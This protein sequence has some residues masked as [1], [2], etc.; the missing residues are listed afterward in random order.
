MAARLRFAGSVSLGV[1]GSVSSV[2][3]GSVCVAARV[4]GGLVAGMDGD[5]MRARVYAMSRGMSEI[6]QQGSDDE[7]DQPDQEAA[8]K[9]K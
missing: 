9:H 7:V 8:N 4:D 3:R 2:G 6:S 5:M 1:A